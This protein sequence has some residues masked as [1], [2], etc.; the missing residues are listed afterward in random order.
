MAISGFQAGLHSLYGKKHPEEIFRSAAIV[1]PMLF[2]CSCSFVT[3][4]FDEKGF[5]NWLL[6]FL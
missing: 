5:F 1:S 6:S 3:H 4:R 2:L